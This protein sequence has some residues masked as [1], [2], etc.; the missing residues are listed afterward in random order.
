M[1]LKFLGTRKATEPPCVFLQA[2]YVQN[3]SVAILIGFLQCKD[4]RV[5][6]E[7]SCLSVQLGDCI[8]DRHII[9]A[10]DV[11]RGQTPTHVCSCRISGSSL[12]SCLLLS[13]S[14][15]STNSCFVAPSYHCLQ[16]F[17][18][19]GPTLVFPWKVKLGSKY[20]FPVHHHGAMDLYVMRCESCADPHSLSL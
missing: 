5:V 19:Q 20:R 14:R 2:K 16:D 17:I 8:F 11:G 18:V 1:Q 7:C 6:S 4:A 3:R 15:A 13:G 10:V 12:Q 9:L